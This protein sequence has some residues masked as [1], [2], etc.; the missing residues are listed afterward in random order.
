M[1]DLSERQKQL[2]TAI[3]EL[4]VKTGEP[5]SSDAIEKYHTL[6]VSPATIRN[7]MV[8]L[9]DAGFLKQPHTSAGRV[10]TAM[11]FRLYVKDLM[12][13][14]QV[15]IVDEVNIRQEL[16]DT[17]TEFDH[18]VQTATRALAKKCST[19]ALAING[20]EI[21][22][23]GAANILDLPE[24]YDIDVTRFVLSMFDE[25][26]ILQRVIDQAQG[27]EP[28]HIIFGEETGFEYLKPTSFAFL[29]FDAG[30][31]RQGVIGVI[32]PNR[33]NFPLVIPYLRYIG[34]VLS[35]AGRI[36]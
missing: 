23:S 6:G 19:L 25:L 7:E 9:T 2:L 3:V 11:G 5:I 26:S 20:N 15:P 30:S 31:T 28:L 13:E 32:G 18:M 27:P 35:E 36:V 22:Y 4:Y 16:L 24:F 21:Y 29:N 12:K 33:L 8:R 1:T 10:P 34:S 17:R 14:R